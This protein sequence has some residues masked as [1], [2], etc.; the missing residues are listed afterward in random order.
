MKKLILHL[1]I[2]IVFF[3]YYSCNTSPKQ[4]KITFVQDTIV[5]SLAKGALLDTSFK[6]KNEGNDTLKIKN[7]EVDCGCTIVDYP[8]SVAPNSS[9][10]IKVQF[11]SKEKKDNHVLQ[12]ILV[13]SNSQPMLHILYLKATIL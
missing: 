6:F 3:F 7:V 2:S 9:A 1:I 8:K 11:D 13:E 5:F 4:A 12:A 10:E